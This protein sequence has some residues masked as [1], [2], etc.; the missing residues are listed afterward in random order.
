VPSRGLHTAVAVLL[1]L[2][3]GG[4][5][6][7][8]LG[9]G[10]A[11]RGAVLPLDPSKLRDPTQLHGRV[12]V[13]GWNI[14]AKS[15]KSLTPA[16]Q[17]RYPHVEV[18]VE[19]SGANMQTRFLL[20]LASGTGAP[21]VMQLQAYES[22][23]FIATERMADLTAVAAKYE[24][25][26]PPSSWANCV[27]EGR[28][29]AIPWDVGPCAVFYKPEL[30][31]RYGIDPARIETWDDYIAAGRQILEKSGGRTKMLPLSPGNLVLMYEILL[32]QV[33]GQVFDRHAR[34][35]ID[36]AQSRR[37]LDILRRMMDAGI[38]ANVDEF[39]HEWMA[40]LNNELIASYPG[41]VWLGGTIKDSSGDYGTS[42]SR[43]G[44]FRLPAV[45][46]GGLRISNRGGSVLVIPDQCAQ[47]E[48]AWAFVEY[49]LCTREAQ[50]AQ[51]RN[52]DLF[53]AFLPALDD[54]FFQQPDD[55]YGGQK[56][57]AL[58]ADGVTAVPVLNRTA[59]WV[60]AVNYTGQSFTKWAV[61]HEPTGP[62]LQTLAQKLERRLGREVAS[63]GAQPAAQPAGGGEAAAT[64]T[65]TR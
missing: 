46:R 2:A 58:F 37:V 50:V 6:L 14:A 55:F 22:P 53:P 42:K 8:S 11:R 19:M 59:D 45:E 49:A 44:V 43:W 16:F 56:V 60:E 33:D 40:G 61:K 63:A 1:V 12:N 57:R 52:Y 13:W 18:S 47:K 9:R 31:A 27:Y 28:V 23:R 17:A 4:A 5:L 29:Y 10:A 7:L 65:P 32:Q 48:A 24:K 38:C 3:V 62:M 36:S 39:S 20:S 41:A 35:A 34:I 51:Y 54:P 21:D 26:F 30:F 64:P 15:L 25:R